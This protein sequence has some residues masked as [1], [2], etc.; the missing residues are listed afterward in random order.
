MLQTNNHNDFSKEMNF[1]E[2]YDKFISTEL[3]RF[4]IGIFD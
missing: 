4:F 3:I 2:N 1:E